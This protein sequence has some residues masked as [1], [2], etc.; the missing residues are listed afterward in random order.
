MR[1]RAGA[2]R[3]E[4]YTEPY[5]S[6][7]PKNPEAAVAPFIEAAERVHNLGMGLNAGHDLSLVN[8][9]YLHTHIPLAG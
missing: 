9:K 4:F 7:Y 8:L 5:A 2:D 1:P 3:V 6:L